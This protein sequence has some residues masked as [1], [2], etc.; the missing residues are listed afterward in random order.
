[1]AVKRPSAS[2]PIW[3]SNSSDGHG[4]AAA[5]SSL[6]VKASRTGRPTASAALAT[7]GSM[8]RSFPPKPPP[9]TAAWTRTLFS[10]RSN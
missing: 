5:K 6:R 9:N 7:I 4:L 8:R 3:S 2:A 10:G 1:M